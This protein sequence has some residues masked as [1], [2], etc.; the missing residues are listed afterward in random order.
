MLA[1]CIVQ[2]Y[3]KKKLRPDDI[4]TFAWESPEMDKWDMDM[5]GMS[6]KDRFKAAKQR[7]GAKN[8]K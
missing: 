7:M 3:S 8:I 5:E 4:M 1:M 6:D 2:P